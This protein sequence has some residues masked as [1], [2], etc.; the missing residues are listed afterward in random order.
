MKRRD[1]GYARLKKYDYK[2][3]KK[4]V[5]MKPKRKKQSKN[6]KI[7]TLTLEDEAPK[8]L[9]A[10]RWLVDRLTSQGNNFCIQPPFRV[11]DNSL[12]RNV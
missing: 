7:N 5:I 11:N 2:E 3:A 6:Q 8:V 9:W 12:E 1:I 4:S 10:T